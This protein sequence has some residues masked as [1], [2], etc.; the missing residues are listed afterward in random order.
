M[1]VTKK[2]GPGVKDI[3]HD[4]T[5]DTLSLNCTALKPLFSII[6]SMNNLAPAYRDQG[7]CKEAEKLE[8]QVTETS[9]K[10]SGE[11]EAIFASDC[12]FAGRTTLG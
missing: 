6:N 9:S 2:G 3:N 1:R 10:C 5:N 7:R 11:G 8:V 12:M 4:P